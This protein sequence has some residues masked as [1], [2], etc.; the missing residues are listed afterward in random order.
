MKIH[1]SQK[2]EITQCL[3]TDEWINKT[4]YT[5]TL[6]CYS[7][8][9]SKEILTHVTTWMNLEDIRLKEISQSQK[10]TVV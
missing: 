8:F 3:P 1:N 9:K 7:A 10:T 2:V 5:H 6:K 4:W